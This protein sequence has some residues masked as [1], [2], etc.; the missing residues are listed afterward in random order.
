MTPGVAQLQAR[1]HT[2]DIDMKLDKTEARDL[3]NAGNRASIHSE[4]RRTLEAIFRH[5]T[6]S[7]LEWM[8][9]VELVG[10]IGTM[11]RTANDKYDLQVGGKRHLMHKPHTKDLT[12]S[13]VID[14]RHF[15]KEAGWSPEAPSEAQ[16]HPD[17]S[18]PTLMV[19]VDHHGTKIYRIDPVSGDASRQEIRPYDPHGFLHHLVHKGQSEEKGQRAPEDT[20]F[21][22]RIADAL[23]AGGKIVVVGHGTGKSNAADHLTEYLRTHHRETYQRVVSELTADLSSVTLPQLLVLAQEAMGPTT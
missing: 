11:D 19:V 13:E 12:E 9:V 3:S 8:D 23:A 5:P 15:L 2:L 4:Q 20:T 7:N 16:T 22:K 21:Y 6:T 14:L 18:A 17:P 1:T 10:K